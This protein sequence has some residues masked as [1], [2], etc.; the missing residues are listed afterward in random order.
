M[1]RVEDFHRAK[2]SR[3]VPDGRDH[4]V[5]AIQDHVDLVSTDGGKLREKIIYGTAALERIKQRAHRHPRAGEA[6]RSAL[7]FRVDQNWVCCRHENIIPSEPANRRVA[8]WSGHLVPH[9]AD[10]ARLRDYAALCPK[11]IPRRSH[12]RRF[13]TIAVRKTA[14]AVEAIAWA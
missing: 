12:P 5:G 13:T 9:R 10:T 14:T 3:R 7:Y 4:F 11:V 2:A 8:R 1:I 6:G